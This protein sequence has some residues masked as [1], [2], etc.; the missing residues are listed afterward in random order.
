MLLVYKHRC[1]IPHSYAMNVRP[2]AIVGTIACPENEHLFNRAARLSVDTQKRLFRTVTDAVSALGYDSERKP[3]PDAV[4]AL[5][6]TVRGRN[7]KDTFR[8]TGRLGSG[9][10]GYV[11]QF[12]NKRGQTLAVKILRDRS[13]ER[14]PLDINAIPTTLACKVVRT[15]HFLGG[16]V[17]AMERATSSA[18]ELRENPPIPPELVEKF[19]TFSNETAVCLLSSGLVCPDWKLG[20]IAYFNPANGCDTFRV[21]DVDG[22]TY[23][24]VEKYDYIATLSCGLMKTVQR[25]SSPER[26]AAVAFSTIA[27]TAYA[28]ELTKCM[29]RHGTGNLR[30]N[31][32]TTMGDNAEDES[33]ATIA[34]TRAQYD[35]WPLRNYAT[36]LAPVLQLLDMMAEIEARPS[37][38]RELAIPK[39]DEL[40]QALYRHFAPEIIVIDAP[41]A[42]LCARPNVTAPVARTAPSQRSR[43]PRGLG[44]PAQ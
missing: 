9:T 12:S 19:N 18:H 35:R 17:Q 28:I 6:L 38:S 10:Y 26:R 36:E 23:P 34:A 44:T 16:T 20:N 30:Y 15:M 37:T 11:Y 29:F 31:L 13:P 33:Q 42:D 5:V 2:D 8:P 41:F 22:V 27:N 43:A 3:L 24:A 4:R 21:I 7:G 39:V 14:V 1:P 32:F 40:K 25:Y